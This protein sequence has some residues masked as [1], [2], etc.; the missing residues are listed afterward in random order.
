MKNFPSPRTLA[1]D[2]SRPL[3]ATENTTSGR[4]AIDVIVALHDHAC[5]FVRRQTRRAIHDKRDD[6]ADNSHHAVIYFDTR[7]DESNC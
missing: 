1:R 3:G 5:V 7:L 2:F 4:S 6:M